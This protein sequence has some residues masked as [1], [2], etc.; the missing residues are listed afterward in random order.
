[1]SNLEA[2]GR[3]L[4]FT[5]LIE[6]ELDNALTSFFVTPDRMEPFSELVL[7]GMNLSTKINLLKKLPINKSLTSY[8]NSIAMLERWRKIRNHVAHSWG[9]PDRELEKILSDQNIIVMLINYPDNLTF[10][11]RETNMNIERLTPDWDIS[12][13]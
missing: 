8:K 11:F 10:S 3:I 5:S 13:Q 6:S 7:N 2:K 9:P 1:M 12:L 4:V